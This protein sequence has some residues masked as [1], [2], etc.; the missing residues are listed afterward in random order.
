MGGL[1]LSAEIL[2]KSDTIF[3][4][5][6]GKSKLADDSWGTSPFLQISGAAAEPSNCWRSSGNWLALSFC[7]W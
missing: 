6:I 3:S 4:T 7:F 2:H 5:S 1:S